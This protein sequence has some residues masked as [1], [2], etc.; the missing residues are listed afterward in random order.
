MPCGTLTA[1]D[2][3]THLTHIIK[4]NVPQCYA[5]SVSMLPKTIQ[6]EQNRNLPLQR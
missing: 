1:F 3:T 4:Q 6:H 5:L 2:A